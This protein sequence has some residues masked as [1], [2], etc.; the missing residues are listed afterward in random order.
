MALRLG[1][2]AISFCLYLLLL[3]LLVRSA[4][5]ALGAQ[6]KPA[7]KTIPA[8]RISQSHYFMGSK[9]VTIAP[10]AICIENTSQLR[11]VLVSRAPDWKVT[12]FR[13]DD[14]TY[15]TEDLKTFQDTGLLSDFLIGRKER[16]VLDRPLRASTMLLNGFKIERLTSPWTT[17][18]FMKLDGVASPAIEKILYAA[19]KL[20]TNGGIPL[21]YTGTHGRADFITGMQN[22]GRRE[23]NLDT[24]KIEKVSVAPSFFSPPSGLKRA[25]SLRDVVSGH[26]NRKKGDAVDIMLDK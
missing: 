12:V 1:F 6:P 2:G 9:Q 17:M 20:P 7:G 10:D 8:I 18:K 22:K 25:A 11:F 16:M 4:D 19:Y 14:K 24:S 13:L 15:F 5:Q 3:G 21:A 26:T 23:T